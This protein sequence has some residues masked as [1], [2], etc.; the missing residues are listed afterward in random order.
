MA[1]CIIAGG[2]ETMSPIPFGGWRIVPNARVAME[3]PDW[4][5]GM[6]LTAEAVAREFKVGREDQDAFS[7]ESHRRAVAAIEAGRFTDEIVPVEVTEVYLDQN[8]KKKER[9]YEVSRDEGPRKDTSAEALAKLKPVFDAC[10][11]P[12]AR[13]SASAV[14]FRCRDRMFIA[15]AFVERVSVRRPALQQPACLTLTTRDARVC[16]SFCGVLPRRC[17]CPMGRSNGGPMG[18]RS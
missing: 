14:A 1:D 7:L 17:A 13:D 3:H 18:R 9:K 6:G 15:M 4:Y 2:V 11:Q 12:V 16:G 8:E 5:W 10:A